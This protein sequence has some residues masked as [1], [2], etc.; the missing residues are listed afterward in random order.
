MTEILESATFGFFHMRTYHLMS[1]KFIWE[2]YV[3]MS[4]RNLDCKKA[5]LRI[6]SHQVRENGFISNMMEGNGLHTTERLIYIGS[7]ILGG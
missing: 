3:R 2:N 7:L 6:F 4:Y 5:G 1:E